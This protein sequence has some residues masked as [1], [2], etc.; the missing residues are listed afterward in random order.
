LATFP[1]IT[2]SFE[3]AEP[4]PRVTEIQTASRESKILHQFAPV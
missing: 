1:G 4:G 3:G 2:P